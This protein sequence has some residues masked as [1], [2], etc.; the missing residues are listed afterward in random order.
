MQGRRR[1][2]AP[3]QEV[4]KPSV[5]RLRSAHSFAIR[6]LPI[7]IILFG[8]SWGVS[9]GWMKYM[10]GCCSDTIDKQSFTYLE[11][12]MS[13]VIFLWTILALAAKLY[14]MRLLVQIINSFMRLADS[15]F[16]SSSDAV[17]AANS[18]LVFDTIITTAEGPRK[19]TYNLDYHDALSETMLALICSVILLI[20]ELMFSY[21]L[22]SFVTDLVD[23]VMVKQANVKT[24]VMHQLFL[25][26]KSQPHQGFSSEALLMKLKSIH[27]IFQLNGIHKSSKLSFPRL[28]C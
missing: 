26:E 22:E 2:I 6:F 20:Y 18:G 1:G 17:V 9:Y 7:W 3:F 8:A 11:W 19:V 10:K 28:S 25:N 15:L 4:L 23:D 14:R 21:Q 27:Q 16:L 13:S 12:I 5:P 24:S